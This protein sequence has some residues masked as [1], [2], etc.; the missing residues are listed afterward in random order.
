[1]ESALLFSGSSTRTLF[2]TNGRKYIFLSITSASENLSDVAFS[3]A[4][5]S[6]ARRI[7][8]GSMV[9]N[10]GVAPLVSTW[11]GVGMGI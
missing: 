10:T 4:A 6:A 9:L 11:C 8:L 3:I 2:S 5:P 7:A 1:M